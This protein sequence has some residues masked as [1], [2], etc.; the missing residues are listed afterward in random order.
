MLEIRGSVKAIKFYE[1]ITSA[2]VKR[3]ATI[4]LA[5]GQALPVRAGR[6]TADIP[7][8]IAGNGREY[9]FSLSSG[10]VAFI[11]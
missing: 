8:A 9:V 3:A 5:D 1:V 2:G 10:E 7:P 11:A 6:A 4:T